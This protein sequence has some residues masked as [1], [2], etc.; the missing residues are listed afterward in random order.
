MIFGLSPKHE[1]GSPSAIMML[2]TKSSL[3]EDV[4]VVEFSSLS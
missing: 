4:I 2:A 1:V 3:A